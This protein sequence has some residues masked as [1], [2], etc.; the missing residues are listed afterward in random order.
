MNTVTLETLSTGTLR[1]TARID[2]RTIAPSHEGT[3]AKALV[4]AAI[5]T[6]GIDPEFVTLNKAAKLAR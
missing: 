4:A 6:L 2:G 5:A 3:D 1:A